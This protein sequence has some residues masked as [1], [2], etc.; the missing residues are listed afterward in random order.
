MEYQGYKAHIE[1]DETA[2]IL[3]GKVLDIKDIITFQG[4]T[5]AELEHEFH[6]SVEDYLEWCAELAEESDKP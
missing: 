5:V 3:F 6:Q 1:I 2:G 4:N